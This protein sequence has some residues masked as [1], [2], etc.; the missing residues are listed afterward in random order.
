MS[1]TDTR[2]GRIMDPKITHLGIGALHTSFNTKISV[3]RS[4]E[5]R[6]AIAMPHKYFT[7]WI[8][9]CEGRLLSSPAELFDL[10]ILQTISPPSRRTIRK[11]ANI[12]GT[13]TIASGFRHALWK[14]KLAKG[15]LGNRE[16]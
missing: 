7:T 5:G 15:S 11:L 12:K 9:I 14:S 8:T 13:T 4:A 3:A 1:I 10:V 2:Y 6:I 16:K